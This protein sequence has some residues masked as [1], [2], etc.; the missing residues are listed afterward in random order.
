MEKEI[1]EKNPEIVIRM[2]ENSEIELTMN[3]QP[4]KLATMLIGGLAQ[5]ARAIYAK[6]PERSRRVFREE[7]LD[8]FADPDS[9]L[10]EIEEDQSDA[11]L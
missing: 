11:D 2:D 5:G 1:R 10:W 8:T 3:G 9:A 4:I 6:L 7:I